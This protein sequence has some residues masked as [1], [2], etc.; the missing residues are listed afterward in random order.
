MWVPAPRRGRER[1]TGPCSRAPQGRIAS[2]ARRALLFDTPFRPVRERRH[3]LSFP[4]S[5]E[6]CHA[7]VHSWIGIWSSRFEGAETRPKLRLRIAEWLAAVEGS[8]LCCPIIGEHE[9]QIMLRTRPKL[10]SRNRPV[11]A[12]GYGVASFVSISDS[13]AWRSD[14]SR[15]ASSGRKVERSE[16]SPIS[17]AKL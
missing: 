2:A 4:A 11:I 6:P 10:G 9:G 3:L 16:R 7:L 8:V 1:C 15:P 12:N 17:S 13:Q 5:L 14:S